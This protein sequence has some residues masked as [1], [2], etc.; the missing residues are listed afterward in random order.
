MGVLTTMPTPMVVG[1][2]Q[3]QIVS[4]RNNNLVVRE[5]ESKE[6]YEREI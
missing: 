1:F 3:Q 6:E 2:W 4:P 5:E